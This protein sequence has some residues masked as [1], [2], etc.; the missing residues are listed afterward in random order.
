MKK[1]IKPVEPLHPLTFT[2]K[3]DKERYDIFGLGEEFSN[4]AK[5]NK[6]P[7]SEVTLTYDQEWHGYEECTVSLQLEAIET[8]EQFRNRQERYTKELQEYKKAQLQYKAWNTKEHVKRLTLKKNKVLQEKQKLLKQLEA[9]IKN[10]S[11]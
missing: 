5:E 1:P 9:E 6:V 4:F 10:L 8:P 7:M 3:I 2:K 11:E